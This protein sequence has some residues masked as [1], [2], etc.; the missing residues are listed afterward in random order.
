M[1]NFLNSLLKLFRGKGK[2]NDQWMPKQ[3]PV[4][5]KETALQ[6]LEKTLT[7]EIQEAKK[8]RA[9]ELQ[10]ELTPVEEAERKEVLPPETVR[11]EV[12]LLNLPFFALSTKGLE[13]MTKVEYRNTVQREDRRFEILW[14]VSS[15]PEY[16][17]P[18]PFDKKVYKAI[19]QIISEHRPPI[20]NPICLGS[21]YALA[22]MMGIK[23]YKGSGVY[24]EIKEALTRITTTSVQSKGAFYNKARSE[25][26]ERIFHLYDQVIFRGEKLKDETIANTNY[27][28]LGSWYL[29]N[30]N[31]RYVK[32]IDYDYYRSLKNPISCRLYELLG[33]KFYGMGDQGF[34]RYKYSTLCQL[35]PVTR[36]K[37][38][39]DAKAALNLSHEELKRT[40]FLKDYQ[41][42]KPGRGQR[43]WYITYWPGERVKEEQERLSME[44]S[45]ELELAP[46]DV[47]PIPP[48]S[49]EESLETLS[50]KAI[51]EKSISP[52]DDLLWQ[53]VLEGME[54]EVT[55][56]N[57]KTYFSEM[58]LIE[59]GEN[60][61]RIGTLSEL[62]L[63]Q[64]QRFYGLIQKHLTL[65]LG[66][67]VDLKFEVLR[68]ADVG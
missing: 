8:N 49:G 51:P 25:W 19:E 22:R 52:E 64:L 39:S 41:W 23:S 36:Q 7:S 60:W 46:S 20:E 6:S 59:L 62:T 11:S 32:P 37:Y 12:N 48:E 29:E 17:Y 31:A 9:K 43:D 4:P 14:K 57:F 44:S 54:Q 27:L 38:L 55:R 63:K 2:G 26:L 5:Q 35:L 3:P 68:E 53:K 40:A 58:R 45:K 33:I 24:K 65:V 28:Y 1:K 56:A 30:L 67:K 15:N 18:G 66:R 61:A 42:S 13:N 50:R 34:I 16:G 10:G 47:R 21:L